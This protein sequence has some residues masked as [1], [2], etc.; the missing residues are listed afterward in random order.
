MSA[1][2]TARDGDFCP[3]TRDC[4]RHGNCAECSMAMYLSDDVDLSAYPADQ[5]R[6]KSNAWGI[7]DVFTFM[8][9]PNEDKTVQGDPRTSF[10]FFFLRYMECAVRTIVD[11]L[12]EI[13]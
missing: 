6:L 9:Q 10:F 8:L 2:E 5:K 7:N 13:L 1:A 3:C 11:R 12:R 4:P